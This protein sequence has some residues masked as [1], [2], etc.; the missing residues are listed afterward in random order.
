MHIHELHV[1][2]GR[3]R[4]V[5]VTTCISIPI[6]PEWVCRHTEEGPLR[7]S[8]ENANTAATISDSLGKREDDGCPYQYSDNLWKSKPW[9]TAV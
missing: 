9:P 6:F 7:E 2:L 8:A 1:L 4:Y 3:V 5:F